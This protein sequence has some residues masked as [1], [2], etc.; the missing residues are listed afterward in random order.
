MQ[1]FVADIVRYLNYTF[2]NL[3]V[4]RPVSLNL[5]VTLGH[6]PNFE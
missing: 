1:V 4:L 6:N 2:E 3:S 5:S